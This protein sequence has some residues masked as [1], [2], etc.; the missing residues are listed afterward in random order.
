MTPQHILVV[1][2]GAREH[3]ICWRLAREAGVVIVTCAP[4]NV[5][6]KDVAETRPDVRAT[7]LDALVSLAREL[8]A[9]LV[10]I[11]PEAPLVAGLADRLFESGIRCFGPTASAAALEGSKAFCREVCR[12]AG[13]PMAAGRAFD[14]VPPAMDFAAA[15]PEPLVVKADGLAGGKGVAICAT[16]AEAEAAIRGAIDGGR[17]GNAGRRIVIEEYLEGREASAIAICD[18]STALLLPAARD[19][20]RLGDG[21]SGPN[22]GGMGAYSPL[23]DI[24]A[25]ALERI[26][27][28]IHQPVLAEMAA[29]GVPFRGALFAGLMLTVDGPRVLEFNARFG[30]PETQ[31]LM[32]RLDAPLGLLMAAAA[33]DR[34]AVA[35]ASL[36]VIGTLL[37]VQAGSTVAVTL[38]ARGYPDAPASGDPIDGIEDA[39]AAG[40]LVFGGALQRTLDGRPTTAGGRVMTVV[41]SGTDV[42]RAAERAYAAAELVHF[43]GRHMR[44]DIGRPALVAVGRGA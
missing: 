24:D 9:D 3:A 27:R 40:A 31:A 10:V 41:G 29:R 28:S 11:G 37:P 5:L 1:G 22:T 8:R 36:G 4:G 26:G 38:A 44:S 2:S 39:R 33:E 12:A 34:L 7:D 32:P 16:L 23:E 6:M 14:S 20:K 17:F 18:A 43:E 35:A 30:D 19:H 25:A 13:V 21:D 15:L 42:V